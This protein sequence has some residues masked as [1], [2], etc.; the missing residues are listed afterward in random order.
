MHKLLAKNF[1]M[2]W[3]NL[4]GDPDAG[5]S[6]EHDPKDPAR[7]LGRGTGRSNVQVLILTPSGRLLHVVTGYCTPKELL[8]EL[9]QALASWKAVKEAAVTVELS[10]QQS[11][12]VTRQTRIGAGYKKS[13]ARGKH[14]WFLAN[15]QRDR[16]V[17]RSFPL[18]HAGNLS[19][20]MITGT[21][22][23]HFGYG[24]GSDGTSTPRRG[25]E[26]AAEKRI[27]KRRAGLGLPTAR[28][29]VRQIPPARSTP[30]QTTT[31]R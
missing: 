18:I 21:S 13:I 16:K 24:T 17:V 22:G 10:D 19:T 29:G 30:G 25:R 20:R 2:S 5:K 14:G 7:T 6:N 12:L 8:W 28:R 9:Q 23:G 3:L 27:N 4:E 26:T 1:R 31:G 11:A 15:A